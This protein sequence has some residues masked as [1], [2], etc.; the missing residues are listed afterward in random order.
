MFNLLRVTPNSVNMNTISLVDTNII[1][2]IFQEE[3]IDNV[4]S[5]LKQI[6]MHHSMFLWNV[7]LL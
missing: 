4:S 7:S 6:K 2:F 1:V 5:D 3:D